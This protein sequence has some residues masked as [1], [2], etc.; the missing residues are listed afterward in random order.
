MFPK[1]KM[2]K[3]IAYNNNIASQHTVISFGTT[4]TGNI[5]TESDIRID[6][7]VNGN[8][9]SKGKIVIGEQGSIA[10]NIS[11]ANAEIS[12]TVKGN[13]KTSETL[14]FK[15]TANIAGDIQI[16]TLSI[17]PGAQFIGSCKMLSNQA[18]TV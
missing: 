10:G 9:D 4:I 5:Q 15:A 16:C 18:E 14:S 2:A 3:E 17:E 11:C 8:I 13:I 12:G 6:G 7:S 1:K